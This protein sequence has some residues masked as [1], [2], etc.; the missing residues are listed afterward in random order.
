MKI[1]F[2]RTGY[3]RGFT[4]I[5]LLAVMMI[6]S[7]LAAIAVPSYRRHQLKARE[8]VLSEDL[9]QM[10][11]AVDAFYADTGHY[12]DSLEDLINKHYLRGLPRDPFTSVNDSWECVAPEPTDDG[13]LVEGGCFDVKSG[14]DQIGT[15]GLPYNEW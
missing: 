14:S 11:R 15:D 12:P 10:R 1:P 7:I 9:Y 13:E 5:E 6:I 4:L 2:H 3:T 8:T